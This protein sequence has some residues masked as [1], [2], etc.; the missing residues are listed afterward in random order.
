MK[1]TKSFLNDF[2]SYKKGE[3]CGVLIKHKWVDGK[4]LPPTK[5]QQLGSYFE[6]LVSKA[7]PKDGNIPKPECK[8]DGGLYADWQLAYENA[9]RVKKVID[10]LGFE[11]VHAGLKTTKGRFEGTIDI[12]ARAKNTIILNGITIQKGDL[13][14]IDL[15]YSGLL[16]DKWSPY[17]WMWTDQQ[18]EHH[19]VQAIQ[20]HF[21]W[22]KIP[23]FYLVCSSRNTDD[24]ELFYISINDEDI[25]R[26]IYRANALV[27]EFT[28]MQL[29][30]FEARPSYSKCR[31]CPLFATCTEKYVLPQ[32]IKI[33]L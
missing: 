30:G 31:K 20:Y 32:P 28:M 11:I 10:D 3:E 5:V 22:D 12:I 4:L 24:L 6:Y 26:H 1:I 9:D 13:V 25:E 29:S 14:I 23:F 21:L 27:E 15:K 17:G 18:K 16:Y 33:S 8:K 19:E 2:I 7:L